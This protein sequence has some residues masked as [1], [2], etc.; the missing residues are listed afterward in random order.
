M[1]SQQQEKPTVAE[2]RRKRKLQHAKK[3]I[4]RNRDS[5]PPRKKRWHASDYDADSFTDERIMPLDEGERRRMVAQLAQQVTLDEPAPPED[6]PALDASEALQGVVIEVSS[7]L[8]RVQANDDI[9]LCTLRGSLSAS[10]TGFSNL[11]AVGDR[12]TVSSDGDGAGVVTAIQPRKNRLARVDSFHAHLEHVIAANI[13]QLLIVAAWREPH[14][15]P[16]LVDRYLIAA[17]RYDITPLICINK[18]DL[19]EEMWDVNVYAEP[20][21]ALGY[22]VLLTSVEANLGI[23]ELRAALHQ[24]TSVLAGMSGVGKSS[25]LAAVKPGF[26]RRI[27]PV[28]EDSGEGQHTTSQ[29][30]MLPFGEGGYIIDTPGVRKFG[31]RGLTP[32]D[33]MAFYP[34]FAPLAQGCRFANCTHLQEPDCAVQAAVK[35]AEIAPWRWENYRKICKDLSV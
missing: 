6:A 29:A 12:V 7:G 19:A 23:D 15:W 4:K 24:K 28:S 30:V 2:H 16:M 33:V 22:T 25:L 21:R 17:A 18:I 13:D 8:C 3:T 26:D 20:Y 14:F 32:A 11:V 31:L 35:R 5:R 9:L 27:A 34:E 1:Q 10:D